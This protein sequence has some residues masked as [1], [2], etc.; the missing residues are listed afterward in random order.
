[1]QA[2]KKTV[3]TEDEYLALEYA[4]RTKHEFFDGRIV[5]MAG[6]T[7]DH[8]TIAGNIIT[9]LNQAL[10]GRPCRVLNSDMRVNI[11]AT[12]RYTYPDISVVC[13]EARFSE[14]DKNA[15]INPVVIIEVLSEST[16]HYD[17][18]SKL[19]DYHRIPSLKAFLAV[20]TKTRRIEHHQ[21]VEVGRWMVEW[22]EDEGE[23]PI[24]CLETSLSLADVYA[25]IDLIKTTDTAS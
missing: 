10:R 12:T 23:V 24:A 5:A 11:A 4:S 13:G 19:S 8:S 7:L 1:M 18:G 9:A 15:L 25:K 3:F 6:G 14:R 17:L 20:D 21:R 22:V 2:A 16:E